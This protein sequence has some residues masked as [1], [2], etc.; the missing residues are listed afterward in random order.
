MIRFARESLRGGGRRRH[1]PAA[2][3][4]GE[5]IKEFP[6]FFLAH[7]KYRNESLKP[8]P[9]PIFELDLFDPPEIAVKDRTDEAVN[10]W[11]IFDK[12]RLPPSCVCVPLPRLSFGSFK[13]LSCLPSFLLLIYW[14]AIVKALPLTDERTGGRAKRSLSRSLHP[15]SPPILLLLQLR[16][17]RNSIL[18][19]KSGRGRSMGTESRDSFWAGYCCW[20]TRTPIDTL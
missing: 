10:R 14:Y 4:K 9:L 8:I 15:P 17:V 3:R 1:F 12:Y 5:K 13:G 11:D 7:P 18:I 19:R 16:N 20:P 2:P 6:I